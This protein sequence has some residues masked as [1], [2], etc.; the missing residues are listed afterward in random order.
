MASGQRF[1]LDM[2]LVLELEPG[3]EKDLESDESLVP[4]RDERTT[5]FKERGYIADN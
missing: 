3:M 1:P 5:W 2:N 4:L